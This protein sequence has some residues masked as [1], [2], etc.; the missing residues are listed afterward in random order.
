MYKN[1]PRTAA[2]QMSSRAG[3][4]HLPDRAG[5]GQGWSCL[6]LLLLLLWLCSSTLQ[7]ALKATHGIAFDIAFLFLA[8]PKGESKGER[9]AGG[10]ARA[11]I[12]GIGSGGVPCS[13]CWH[14]RTIPSPT[15]P[16]ICLGLDEQPQTLG[17]AEPSGQGS[18]A[19]AAFPN[20]PT[21]PNPA[22]NESTRN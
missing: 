5:L 17:F 18:L 12:W 7:Q 1:I 22:V 14:S 4:G 3:L 6:L 16:G 2:S 19:P 10:R 15:F 20:I 21:R 11:G 9:S 8:F 13:L